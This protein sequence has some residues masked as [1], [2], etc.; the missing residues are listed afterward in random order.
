MPLALALLF[1]S[2]PALANAC[3][4]ALAATRFPQEASPAVLRAAVA[5][6]DDQ[7]LALLYADTLDQD[8]HP[9]P[10]Q[11][12]EADA[13]RLA[14]AIQNEGGEDNPFSPNVARAY[15]QRLGLRHHRRGPDLLAL[16]DR[17][18][19]FPPRH[20]NPDTAGWNDR[21][22]PW[23]T[24]LIRNGLPRR[25]DVDRL[26]LCDHAYANEL[27]ARERLDAYVARLPSVSLLSFPEMGRTPGEAFTERELA[28]AARGHLGLIEGLRRQL[29][30]QRAYEDPYDGIDGIWTRLFD[31]SL[32]VWRLG[33]PSPFGHLAPVWRKLTDAPHAEPA[34]RRARQRMGRWLAWTEGAFPKQRDFFPPRQRGDVRSDFVS[35]MDDYA[36]DAPLATAIVL[37]NP[38]RA[39][40]VVVPQFVRYLRSRRLT[41]AAAEAESRRWLGT[42]G[43]TTRPSVLWALRYR[44]EL[45]EPQTFAVP[46]GANPLSAHR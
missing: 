28:L 38:D 27:G 26:A 34:E 41:G 1:L 6:P 33:Q 45:V 23:A 29:T 12:A 25:L 5:A 4:R 19:W 8:F 10:R 31:A 11:Q 22:H 17:A 16:W 42:L 9:T 44:G 7:G 20:P 14:I 36:V 43:A 21:W 40:D 18:G 3:L 30:L 37:R 35:V 2:S 13:I 39:V 46:N 24:F 15:F 32:A